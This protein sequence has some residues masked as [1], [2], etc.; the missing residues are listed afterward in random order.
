[1]WR[2]RTRDGIFWSDWSFDHG[3]KSFLPLFIDFPQSQHIQLNRFWT[4]LDKFPLNQFTLTLQKSHP[5]QNKHSKLIAQ[6]S[7]AL[8]REH[9]RSRLKTQTLTQ[10]DELLSQALLPAHIPRQML[11]S[12]LK[13][14]V[15]FQ[16]HSHIYPIKIVTEVYLSLNLDL[17]MHLKKNYQKMWLFTPPINL[18]SLYY[19]TFL[20]RPG[21][22]SKKYKIL[23]WKICK[24]STRYLL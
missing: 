22:S 17:K 12:W 1:M 3:Y 10:S 23:C 19:K 18:L 7:E 2:N 5:F 21:L 14:K 16:L 6:Y 4:C 15:C 20:K 11:N 9:W 8:L 13:T 24:E